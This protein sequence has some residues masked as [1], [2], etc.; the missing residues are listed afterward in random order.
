MRSETYVIYIYIYI[1]IY[2]LW[3]EGDIFNIKY[4]GHKVAIE[5]TRADSTKEK[6]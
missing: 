3:V 4:G 1:Y 2:T 6:I 5:F